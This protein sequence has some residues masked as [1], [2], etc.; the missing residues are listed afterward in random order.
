MQTRGKLYKCLFVGMFKV[1]SR[2]GHYNAG[3]LGVHWIFDLCSHLEKCDFGI[4]SALNTSEK[5][6]K[7]EKHSH[8]A[9]RCTYVLFCICL[10]TIKCTNAFHSFTVC[11]ICS[12]IE[13]YCIAINADKNR[14]TYDSLIKTTKRRKEDRY[15]MFSHNRSNRPSPIRGWNVSRSLT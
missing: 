9:I 1:S 7:E 5:E 2:C 8:N 14:Y 13:D 4:S 11:S 15:V 6:W 12:N 10:Y 3:P